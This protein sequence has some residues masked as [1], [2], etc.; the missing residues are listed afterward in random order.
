MI[1]RSCVRHVDRLVCQTLR[2]ISLDVLSEAVVRE[3]ATVTLQHIEA[4]VPL[5]LEYAA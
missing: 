3:I 5:C 4:C 1:R 2:S